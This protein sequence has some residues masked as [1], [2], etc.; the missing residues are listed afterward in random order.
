MLKKITTFLF[1]FLFFKSTMGFYGRGVIFHPGI[2]SVGANASL[3]RTQHLRSSSV[4]AQKLD[5]PGMGFSASLATEAYFF[6][7]FTFIA[8][9]MGYLN[10][11]ASFHSD[12]FTGSIPEITHYLKNDITMNQLSLPVYLNA[13]VGKFDNKFYAFGGVGL[14]YIFLNKRE[15]DRVSFHMNTPD[16]KTITPVVKGRFGFTNE[17]NTGGYF[18][19][20]IGKNF[21][22]KESSIGVELR[23]MQ[24]LKKWNYSI[25]Y[26][27]IEQL[28]PVSLKTISLRLIYSI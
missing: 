24:D 21:K 11:K 22:V 26:N 10:T 25:T 8:F 20:G 15:V 6:S 12:D 14:K 16:D 13:A 3:L 1:I 18:L 9:E 2:F 17:K 23:Y 28:I 5:W 7:K 4:P 27:G 19:L